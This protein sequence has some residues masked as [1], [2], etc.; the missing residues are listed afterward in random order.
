VLSVEI[1]FSIESNTPDKA[2]L[3]LSMREDV[4]IF[5]TLGGEIMPGIA[6]FVDP[7][8]LS[9]PDNTFLYA[10]TSIT[11]DTFGRIA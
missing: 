6:S 1:S 4:P 7:M 2:G 5:G 10:D 9:A 3:M 8:R 11:G